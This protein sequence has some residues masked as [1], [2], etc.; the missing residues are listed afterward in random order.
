MLIYAKNGG[1][2]KE[3]RVE[4]VHD[5]EPVDM[6][7]WDRMSKLYLNGSLRHLGDEYEGVNPNV[8]AREARE[9][10]DYVKPVY[11]FVHGNTVLGLVPFECRFDSGQAGVIVVPHERVD[12]VVE[13]TPGMDGEDVSWIAMNRDIAFINHILAGEVYGYRAYRWGEEEDACWQF[14]GDFDE[15]VEVIKMSLPDEYR[16][17]LNGARYGEVYPMPVFG[18]EAMVCF[19]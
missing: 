11:A 2:D 8:P 9:R 17:L 1:R 7:D 10:W 12:K 4:I 19:V 5:L 13:K 6:S 15:V 18:P 16:D 3:Y 14:I